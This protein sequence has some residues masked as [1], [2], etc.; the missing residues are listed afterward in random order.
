VKCT[1][2][3]LFFIFFTAGLREAQTAGIKLLTR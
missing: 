3:V 1:P 2:R